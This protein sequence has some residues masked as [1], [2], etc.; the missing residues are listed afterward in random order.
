MPL[1]TR[2]NFHIIG[3]VYWPAVDKWFHWSEERLAVIQAV[4]KVL[5]WWRNG[6]S[7]GEVRIYINFPMG[8]IDSLKIIQGESLVT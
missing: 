3:T 4:D 8:H 2:A 6:D 7:F 1:F 5:V